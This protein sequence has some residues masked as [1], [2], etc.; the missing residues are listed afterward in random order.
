[1][2]E[3]F[4]F[5]VV[6]RGGGAACAAL[7]MRAN[8]HSVAIL[9]KTELYGGTT[10]MSGG[11]M[12]IPN[13][14]FMAPAGVPDSREQAAEYLDKVVG[15][16]NDTP[17]ASRERRHAYVEQATKMVDFLTDQGVEL[18][19]IPSWPDY[20][21][22][23]GHSVPGRTV[24]S[25]LFD[26]NKLGEWKTKLRPGFLPLPANL[27]EAMQLPLFKRSWT[28]KKVLAR[29]IGRA[30]LGKI[31][32]KNLVTAGSALQ[33]QM[34]Y[35]ALKA[36]AEVRLDSAV[37]QII[38]EDGRVTG[39][40]TEKDG[41]EWRIRARLGVLIN[42]GGYAR[43]QRMLD[44]Y[45]PGT[46]TEWTNASP[47][48]TGEMIEEGMR[49]GG[50]VAQMDGRI[51]TQIVL[52]PGNPSLKPPMQGDV[53]KPH[54]I[55]VDQSGERYMRET[56]SYIDFCRAMMERN[57]QTPAVPSWMVLDSQF[58]DKYMLVGKMPGSKKPDTWFEQGFLTKG[59]TI[60]Q[61]A[62]ACGIDPARLAA[63][64]DRF[65][66]F[67]RKGRDEDFHRGDT[68]YDQ[69]LGDPLHG[70]SK[71][72]GTVEKGPFF[73]LRI[74]P[75]DVSTLGG[76][77]TDQHARVLRADGSAIDGLYATG[78]SAASVMGR[79]SAGAGAS[80]GPSFTWA[81][82]AAKHAANASQGKR[83]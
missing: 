33:A 63:S 50:A 68:A 38:V 11:V 83:G 51:G 21:E 12:W 23:P 25:K 29:V 47:G 10:A 20:Y 73:A 80:I 17:G 9:E 57:K 75:G 15:D 39:V 7:V 22:M 71:T 48:D 19:R 61:L 14:R 44:T 35:F 36:G 2:D 6:G 32:G 37:R 4:D 82:V 79:R 26:I 1:M 78:T 54:T 53:S 34:L 16:H 24:V 49:I 67:V 64:V 72:L 5:V 30:I 81:Y 13:N 42:A 43:N 65:N 76:L 40:V 55:V 66:G 70:P 3:T 77:V 41:A 27:D 31:M 56:G 74:Y 59:D 60:E 18:R 52:P 69:W 58:T 46:S 28:G 8:G 62:T 45:I